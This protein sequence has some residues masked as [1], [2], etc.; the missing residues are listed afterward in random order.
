[1]CGDEQN[2]N[3]KDFFYAYINWKEKDVEKV[4]GCIEKIMCVF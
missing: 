1:M 3:C 4:I 2:F